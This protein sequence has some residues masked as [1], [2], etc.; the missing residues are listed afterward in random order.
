[1][2]TWWN[3]LRF[4][5]QIFA[6]MAIVSTLLLVLQ[7]FLSLFALGGGASMDTGGDFDLSMGDLEPGG[8]WSEPQNV[9]TAADTGIQ[10]FTLQGIVSFFSVFGWSALAML[11]S[12]R[13]YLVSLLLSF[14]FGLIAMFA[15]AAA[16][17]LMA[18]LRADGSLDVR[19]AVG[20]T[21]SVYLSVPAHRAS[22]GKVSILLQE[23]MVELEALTDQPD[24]IPTGSQVLVVGVTNQTTLLVK[25]L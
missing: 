14:L 6:I 3:S 2:I 25:Q 22:V 4:V 1:M 24:P 20:K 8:D 10:L 11:G 23:R 19:C 5:E 7:F 13:G 17:R 18:R 9:A 15:I 16:F 21:G 12:G